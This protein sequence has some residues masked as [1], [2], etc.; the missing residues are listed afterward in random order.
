MG[1]ISQ[2]SLFKVNILYYIFII[3][4]LLKLTSD[5]FINSYDLNEKEKKKIINKKKQLVKQYNK[6]ILQDQD[7][8]ENYIVEEKK[9]TQEDLEEDY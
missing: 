9:Q 4:S 5:A 8:N 3:A 7:D 6:F 1:S 2:V